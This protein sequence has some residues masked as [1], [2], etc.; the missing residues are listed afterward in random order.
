MAVID[1]GDALL[2]WATGERSGTISRLADT[3]LWFASAAGISLQRHTAAEYAWMD[4][5]SAL[6]YLDVSR[7]ENRWSIAPPVLTRLPAINGLL[8][9]TG[10]RTG[11]LV[12][13][14]DGILANCDCWCSKPSSESVIPLPRSIYL[15]PGS[16]SAVH[17]I[18]AEL[19]SAEPD[20]IFS[21]CS[22]AK[23]STTLGATASQLV[24]IAGPV[25]DEANTLRVM[26]IQNLWTPAE[27]RYSMWEST[28]EPVEGSVHRWDSRTGKR[29]GLLSSGRWVGGPRAAVLY[30]GLAFADINVLRWQPDVAGPDV[31]T[32]L[33]PM[34]A[35]LPT[36][37]DRVATLATGL[38]PARGLTA[39]KYR[40]IP[41][42]TGRRIACSL[43]QEL[44]MI[45]AH[46]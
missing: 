44:E 30:A 29:F 13:A 28:P 32:L 4:D 36:I 11:R 2:S 39:L 38:R 33:V 23:L 37:H 3:L 8:F 19:A 9:L 31:G 12:R 27:L 41:A 22:S 16:E 5:V 10:G 46:T 45:G 26:N 40:G 6:G 24:G 43:G 21:S 18:I 14:L 1:D 17:A 20:L 35:G 7:S 42:A 25:G 15:Q 34:K